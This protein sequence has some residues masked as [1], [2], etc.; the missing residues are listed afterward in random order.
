MSIACTLHCFNIGKAKDG[1]GGD[2]EPR[3]GWTTGLVM[4]VSA[5]VGEW[6]SSDLLRVTLVVGRRPTGYGATFGPRSGK[7]VE[8]KALTLADT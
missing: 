6:D 8:L 7:A 2:I 5:A 4:Y 3:I 1:Q